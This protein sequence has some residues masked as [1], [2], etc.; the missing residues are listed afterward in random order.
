[1][2]RAAADPADHGGCARPRV[3]QGLAALLMTRPKEATYPSGR[4][5]RDVDVTMALK[6]RPAE[7]GLQ[8]GGLGMNVGRQLASG[9]DLEHAAPADPIP[10]SP[11][12]LQLFWPDDKMWYLVEIQG[13][14]LKTRQA[15]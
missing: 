14:N 11:R 5:M 10:P 7:V 8:L 15:K 9:N 3:A 12:A 1:M 6:G 4:L 2:H 13:V